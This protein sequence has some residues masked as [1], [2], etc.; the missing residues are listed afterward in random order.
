[1]KLTVRL[2]I[3]LIKKF[4]EKTALILYHEL[5]LSR[6]KLLQEIGY[7]I[8]KINLMDKEEI[9][10]KFFHERL[11]EFCLGIKSIRLEENKYIENVARLYRQSIRKRDQIYSN[12]LILQFYKGNSANDIPN[13]KSLGNLKSNSKNKFFK[14]LPT[15]TELVLMIINQVSENIPI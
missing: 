11:K 6:N 1:M 4:W 8:M 10:S 5:R 2:K 9:I 14:F 13:L 12:S 3:D 7:N 15:Q